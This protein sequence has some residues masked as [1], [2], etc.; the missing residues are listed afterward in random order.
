MEGAR[1]V[2]RRWRATQLLERASSRLLAALTFVG[3]VLIL[4]PL[5]MSAGQ[6]S[7]SRRAIGVAAARA[8]VLRRQAG[9]QATSCS[10]L[11]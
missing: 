1:E 2:A 9:R 11:A 7:G 10:V 3:S 8:A 5:S 6:V 4:T